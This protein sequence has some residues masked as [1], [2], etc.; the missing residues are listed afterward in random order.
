MIKIYI[1][2]FLDKFRSEVARVKKAGGTF[3]TNKKLV[4]PVWNPDIINLGV[5]RSIGD[6]YF[7]KSQ[8]TEGKSTGLIATPFIKETILGSNDEFLI[9][10]SDG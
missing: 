9:L 2:F 4:H 7:K 1:I 10:A 8:Y 6:M 3:H 5:T